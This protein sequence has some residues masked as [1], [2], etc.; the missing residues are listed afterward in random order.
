MIIP[1]YQVD[2]FTNKVFTGNYA[3]VC[4]LKKWLDDA[5]LLKIAQENNLSET[6]FI[7]QNE[8]SFHIRWF[9]PEIEMDLCGHATLAAA[10]VIFNHLHFPEDCITFNSASGILK[11]IKKKETIYLDFPARAPKKAALPEIIKNGLEKL[12]VEVYKSRD[13]MLVYK[14]E[15][16]VKNV[17]PKKEI[18]DLIN[19]DPGGI[20]VT[21]PGDKVDFVS[22]FFTPQASIFEDPV[23]GSAHCSL[24][25]FWAK[26][27]RKET[28][29][30]KQLSNREGNLHCK[31]NKNRILIGGKAITYLKGEIYV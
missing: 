2:A 1:I 5:I 3:A 28:L 6:V 13:Y 25:P 17:Q 7:I 16:E 15:T 18:W 20:I 11:A 8:K 23:T 21:A 12:P 4:L 9:T 19:L 24:V 26:K 31:F 29:A 14:N 10:H 22:R 30:A 27:L